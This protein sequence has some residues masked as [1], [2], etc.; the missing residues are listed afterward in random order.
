M[1]S[2]TGTAI[3]SD[4]TMVDILSVIPHIIEQHLCIECLNDMSTICS[5]AILTILLFTLSPTIKV[6]VDTDGPHSCQRCQTLLF[7]LTVAPTIEMTIRTNNQ[8]ET[9]PSLTFVIRL[10]PLFKSF[11]VCRRSIYTAEDVFTR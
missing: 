4:S 10:F 2:T 3:H 7:I 1:G 6:E 9:T 8:R 11:L 5:M